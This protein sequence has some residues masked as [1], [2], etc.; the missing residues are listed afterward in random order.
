MIGG[1]GGSYGMFSPPLS[2]PRP[3]AALS[4]TASPRIEEKLFSTGEQASLSAGNSLI[5]LVRRRLVN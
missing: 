1:G 5:N 4:N 3:F 2:F